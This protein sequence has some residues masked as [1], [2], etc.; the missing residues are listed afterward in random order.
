MPSALKD[1]Q[2][3]IREQLEWGG[4]A[5]VG[6]P[7][8]FVTLTR[9]EAEA[10]LDGPTS[11]IEVLNEI[12]RLAMSISRKEIEKY[13][14]AGGMWSSNGPRPGECKGEDSACS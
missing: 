11:P 14:E 5:P 8:L 1:A 13:A 4:Q 7:K 3:S 2:A 12:A 6:Q 10:I 9:A